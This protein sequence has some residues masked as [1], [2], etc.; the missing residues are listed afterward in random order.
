MPSVIM[1]VIKVLLNF[2]STDQ[3]KVLIEDNIKK[4]LNHETDGI[5]KD[6]AYTMLTSIVTSTVNEVSANM[7]SEALTTLKK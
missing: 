1:F 5:T 3:N 4:L 6:L 2:I 7:V